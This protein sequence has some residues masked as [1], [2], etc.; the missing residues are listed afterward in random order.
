[1]LIPAANET[2]TT[3]FSSIFTDNGNIGINVALNRFTSHS[4]IA[5]PLLSS[6]SC[7]SL[8]ILLL[9]LSS[10]F[11][12]A[13]I[14]TETSLLFSSCL[15]FPLPSSSSSAELTSILNVTSVCDSGRNFA[16]KS[17]LEFTEPPTPIMKYS[18]IVT[19]ASSFTLFLSVA[20]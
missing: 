19:S 8:I 15:S 1:M 5:P 6:I 4:L 14:S 3:K 20:S 7:T 9:S 13:S 11:R 10:P 16:L 17:R 12:I 18:L 2:L